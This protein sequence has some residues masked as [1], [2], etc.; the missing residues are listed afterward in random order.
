M[1]C[2]PYLPDVFIKLNIH[3]HNAYWQFE[4]IPVINAKPWIMQENSRISKHM[5]ILCKAKGNK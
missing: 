1:L 5:E 2:Y 4:H 3:V